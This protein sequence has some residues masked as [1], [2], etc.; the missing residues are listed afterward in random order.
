M[1]KNCE[2]WTL[3]D[4]FIHQTIYVLWLFP[5]AQRE[6]KAK[7]VT[8]LA[9]AKISTNFA[10]HTLIGCGWDG[11]RVAGVEGALVSLLAV[12]WPVNYLLVVQ[13]VRKKFAL[14]SCWIGRSNSSCRDAKF[15]CHRIGCYDGLGKTFTKW[16]LLY[17]NFTGWSW[18]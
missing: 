12:N 17:G 10:K 11:Q 15:R 4:S 9:H 7:N 14:K 13:I 1:N 3:N 6:N 8:S 18:P 2:L 5:L 16:L